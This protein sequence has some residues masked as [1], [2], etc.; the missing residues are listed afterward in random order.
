MAEFKITINDPKTGKSYKK[1]IEGPAVD[2][3]NGKKIKD[4]ISGDSI[5]LKGYELEITGGSDAQGFPMRKDTEGTNRTRPLLVSGVG[6]REKDKGIK[7]RKTVA[8]NTI[9]SKTKQINLKIIKI[10]KDS[11]IDLGFL[12]K[13]E[14]AE[15]VEADKKTEE[16]KAAAEQKEEAK[17]ETTEEKKEE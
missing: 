5:G 11:L 7:Q 12:T 16:A 2:V 8:G 9:N 10:G 14:E 1:V 4:K 13:V 15:K 6:F 17:E 3:L